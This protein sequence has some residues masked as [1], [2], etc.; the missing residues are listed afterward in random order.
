MNNEF[1]NKDEN[2]QE[3][4]DNIGESNNAKRLRMLGDSSDENIHLKSDEAVKG[5]FW[6]NFWFKYKWR[7]IIISA[8]LLIFLIIGIQML[9]TVKYDV[10]IM[11]TGPKYVVHIQDNFT[12]A[13]GSFAKDY[14]DDGEVNALFTSL[15]YMTPEQQEIAAAGNEND[16]MALSKANRESYEAFKSQIMSGRVVF[17]IL[18]PSLYNEYSDIF[19]NVSDVLGYT[20]DSSLLYSEKA[21]YLK[22]TDFGQYFKCFNDLPDDALICIMDKHV[23]SDEDELEAAKDLFVSIMEFKA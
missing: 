15:V 14:N 9:T 3:S 7:V 22:K 4:V 18:D 5:E 12:E 16:K 11:Y 21:V 20:P 17:Y 8:F 13:F 2:T 10:T 6:P 19:A 23:F 1:E